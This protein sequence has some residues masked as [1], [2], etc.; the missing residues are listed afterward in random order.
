MK[1]K[2]GTMHDHVLFFF[3]HS[4]NYFYI[5]VDPDLS[6]SR[7]QFKKSIPPRSKY[8]L[9][10]F[11]WVCWQW[12]KQMRE[13]KVN[14]K[15]K[16]EFASWSEPHSLPRRLAIALRDREANPSDFSNYNDPFM[17]LGDRYRAY[18]QHHS[19]IHEKV[20]RNNEPDLDIP[21]DYVKPVF[22]FENSLPTYENTKKDRS[23]DNTELNRGNPGQ[24]QASIHAP[25]Q[26]E[27]PERGSNIQ[28]VARSLS[29][30]ERPKP[31]TSYIESPE[32]VASINHIHSRNHAICLGMVIDCLKYGKLRVQ[33]DRKRLHEIMIN[34]G[35]S[36]EF[37]SNHG[38]YM[39]YFIYNLHFTHAALWETIYSAIGKIQTSNQE[40]SSN[41]HRMAEN[42]NIE[43]Y[44]QSPISP[45]S[46]SNVNSISLY[47]CSPRTRSEEI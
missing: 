27:R 29:V 44:N 21:E 15:N 3:S 23:D 37:I 13:N 38:D 47:S 20:F 40:G 42:R 10:I 28:N 45:N 30:N 12:H 19:E 18:W 4:D 35:F 5:M 8:R 22:N 14:V 26:C 2:K 34:A 31:P 11:V 33:N 17:R 41:T 1:N 25:L 24:N 36:C 46:A 43:M 9:S 32:L 39:E 7:A 16:L 6:S